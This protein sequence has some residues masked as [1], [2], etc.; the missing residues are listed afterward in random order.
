MKNPANNTRRSLVAFRLGCL[1]FF[2]PSVTVPVAASLIGPWD[3]VL[4]GGERGVAHVF[5]YADGTLN[6]RAVFT[7]GK[8]NSNVTNFL[9]GA[10]LNGRWSYA[11]P[12]GANQLVGFIN[13]VSS[14][15]GTTMLTTNG[16]SFRGAVRGAKLTLLALGSPG[17]VM[18]RGI[19]LDGTNDLS[20]TYYATGKRP[21]AAGTF[22]E[23]FDLTPA[24]ELEI[25]TNSVRTSFDCSVTN[26]TILTNYYSTT[27]FN[28]II[29]V[30]N[31]IVSATITQQVC[32]ITNTFVTSLVNDFPAN[33]YGAVGEGA[34]Y[35]YT[36]RLLVSR[37][38]YA[39]FF[40]GRGLNNEFITVYAGPFN[41]ATGRGSLVG[42]DGVNSNV[43]LVIAP[44][45]QSA[46][47]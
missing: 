44:R 8:T 39:A 6:G 10:R 19:P 47:P 18:F 35:A 32:S 13:S 41:P 38:K 36:G 28:S 17:Q 11:T 34:A 15:S 9:G 26:V 30:T 46:G 5:F 2:L 1:L 7:P 45:P 23:I 12:T 40:Q 24:P 31:Y 20:G 14:S 3:C 4:S 43:K 33:Y 22:V 21:G 42:N 29:A 16:F 27:N 37:Q 25:I